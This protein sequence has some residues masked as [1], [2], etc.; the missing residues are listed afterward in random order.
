[1][2]NESRL[3]TW[4][5]AFLKITQLF[6][7]RETALKRGGPQLRVQAILEPTAAFCPRR[8]YSIAAAHDNAANSRYIAAEP[9][10]GTMVMNSCPGHDPG[11]F[12]Q[13]CGV[14]ITKFEN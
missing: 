12:V 13:P 11:P 2:W 8:R 14:R 10:S 6:S 4:R 3:G 7:R 1:M 5:A 9:P